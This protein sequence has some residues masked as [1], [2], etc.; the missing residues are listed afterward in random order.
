MSLRTHARTL[1]H[2][3][4]GQPM[5]H[6]E[7]AEVGCPPDRGRVT[8]A[9]LVP[10]RAPPS[11]SGSGRQSFGTERRANL[12]QQAASEASARTQKDDGHLLVTPFSFLNL[13]VRATRV[14]HRACGGAVRRSVVPVD[15]FPDRL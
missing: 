2:L 14:S 6:R 4:R 12:F 10:A 15:H 5:A 1:Q 3:H 8:S 9:K 11:G 13:A 7:E